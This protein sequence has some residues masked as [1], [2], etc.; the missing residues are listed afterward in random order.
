MQAS[1][2]MPSGFVVHSDYVSST[3]ALA[4][5]AVKPQTLYSYVSRGMVRRICVDGK[6]CLYNR[7]DIHRLKARSTARSGHGAVAGGALQWGE[8]VLATGITEITAQGPRYREHLALQLAREGCS[9]ESVAE[10]LWTTKEIN[11]SARWRPDETL[12]RIAPQV[13]ALAVAYPR[14]HF[15][16]LLT[17][18]VLLLCIEHSHHHREPKIEFS[19]NTA[20]ALV[21]AL[22]MAFGF[23]GPRRCFVAPRAHEG[24]AAYI[25]RAFGVDANRSQ[26]RVLN[27][28]LVLLADHE[29][30]PATFAARIAASSRV[31]LHSCIGAALHVHFGSALGLRCDSVEEALQAASSARSRG[32]SGPVVHAGPVGFSHPLYVDGDPRANEIL[33][34]ALGLTKHAAATREALRTLR[35]IDNHEGAVSLNAALVVLCRALGLNGP[36]AGGLLAVSRSAGWIAHV[37]EQYKQD[38][39]IRP[40]GKFTPVTAAKQTAA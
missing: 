39:M 9:Y 8:P 18:I 12:L 34:L 22:C 4:V 14:I 40:R 38:F 17:E 7:E 24:I 26:T 23:A 3:E 20:R 2:S 35:R 6:N 36:V 5:L 27:S 15:R 28:A 16:Q 19:L 11:A 1:A 30:S 32:N 13:A 25:L 29:F 33:E 31:D 21:Q 37:I 10:Y